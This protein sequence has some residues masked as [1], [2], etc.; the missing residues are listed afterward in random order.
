MSLKSGFLSLKKKALGKL[1]S[2]AL[3]QLIMLTFNTGIDKA[4]SL[5]SHW[6]RDRPMS[7]TF[8]H[9]FRNFSNN[10]VV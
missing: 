7:T 5:T 6:Q 4:T 8:S 2:G 3:I 9:Q 1:V 10:V